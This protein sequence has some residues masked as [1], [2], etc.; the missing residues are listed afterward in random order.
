MPEDTYCS[1]N[2]CTMCGNV[3]DEWDEQENF[4]FEYHIGY[5]STH[6]MEHV[7]AR[8]CCGCFDKVLDYII[9]NSKHN[10][11]LGEYRCKL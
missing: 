1:K 6:D 10:P 8:F 2:V 11:V 4:G 3:L 9:A 7:Y 5:G